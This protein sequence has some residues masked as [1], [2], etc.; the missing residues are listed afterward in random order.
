MLHARAAADPGL[1]VAYPSYDLASRPQ[2]EVVGD[3]APLAWEYDTWNRPT[4]VRLPDVVARDPAGDFRG[5]SR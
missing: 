2:T 5:F 4:A 1:R 3:R